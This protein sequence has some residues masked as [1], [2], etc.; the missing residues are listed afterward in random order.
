MTI[1]HVNFKFEG[2]KTTRSSNS[3]STRQTFPPWTKLQRNGRREK[4]NTQSVREIL[5]TTTW[6]VRTIINWVLH[7]SSVLAMD[8]SQTTHAARHRLPALRQ[9]LY[10]IDNGWLGC[11]CKTKSDHGKEI[12]PK[13]FLQFSVSNVQDYSTIL[14]KSSSM[15]FLFLDFS[16]WC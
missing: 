3:D 11:V 16:K 7:Y 8:N 2:E 4:A 12:Q 10:V 5:Q 14:S 15:I 9:S 6:N 13:A 1:R